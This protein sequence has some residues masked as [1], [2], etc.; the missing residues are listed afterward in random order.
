MDY[1]NGKNGIKRIIGVALMVSLL[2]FGAHSVFAELSSMS[3]TGTASGAGSNT[4]RVSATATTSTA[5]SVVSI[6]PTTP[7]TGVAP[8]IATPNT[9]A[10]EFTPTSAVTPAKTKEKE[11]T[12]SSQSSVVSPRKQ[13]KSRVILKDDSDRVLGDKVSGDKV[14]GDTKV[15]VKVE[16][17]E[18]VAAVEVNLTRKDGGESLYIGKT[19]IE[20]SDTQGVVSWDSANTP[21]GSYE[22]TT[23]ITKQDGE[24]VLGDSVTVVVKNEEE[25]WIKTKDATNIGNSS[26]REVSRQFV[27]EKFVEDIKSTQTV[28]EEQIKKEI[29]NTLKTFSEKKERKEVAKDLASETVSLKTDTKEDPRKVSVQPQKPAPDFEKVVAE[30]AEDLKDAIKRGDDEKKKEIINEIVETTRTVQS[31][32]SLAVENN[33][34]ENIVAQDA[35]VKNVEAG[36]AKLEQVAIEQ[37]SGIVDVKNFAVAEVA[38]AEVV[39]KPDGTKTASKISFK[40]KALPNSFATLYI[41]SIPIVVTVKTDNDGNWNYTLDKELENGEHKVFVAITDVKGTVVARSNPLP[42]VKEAFAITVPQIVPDAGSS[43]SFVEDNYFYGSIAVIILIVV[44]IFILLGFKMKNT[45]QE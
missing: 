22:L 14:S 4:S 18:K 12:V 15:S 33:K 7:T 11:K 1:L 26:V 17:K 8:V 21:D 37:Q 10:T 34:P 40:G 16:E 24:V 19:H 25:K 9:I 45:P 32:G 5:D 43:P 42:F 13:V 41:F 6:I 23:L 31:D 38:V 29:T 30:K 44:A 35:L 36:V 39:E 27:A 2:G 28:K 3:T 20:P